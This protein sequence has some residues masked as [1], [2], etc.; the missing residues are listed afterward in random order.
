MQRIAA[1]VGYSETAF[2]APSGQVWRTR[3]FSPENEVPFCGHATVALGAVLAELKGPGRY[4][5]S[6]ANGEIEAEAY[7]KGGTGY[8]TLRSLPT[9]DVPGRGVAGLRW[10]PVFFR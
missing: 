8:S 9:D 5:L 1:E 7:I 6:L 4:R 2:A 3:Y 10:S